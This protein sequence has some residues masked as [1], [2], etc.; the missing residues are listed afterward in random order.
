MKTTKQTGRL[1]GLLFLATFIA[2]VIG[3]INRGLSEGEVGTTEFIAN[4]AANDS[5]MKL[6]IGLDMLTGM[7][8]IVISI[9]LYPLME[10]LNKRIAIAYVL[11]AAINFVIAT[12]SNT[13]HLSLLYLVDSGRSGD[14]LQPF[15]TMFYN[16]YYSLH[17]LILILYSFNGATL[18]YFLIKS[19]LTHRWIAIWGLVASSLVFSG[20]FL[21]LIEVSVPFVLFAQNGI[22]MLT[23]ICY[24][25]VVG[26]RKELNSEMEPS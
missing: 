26:F 19:G 4:L 15:S 18:Y 21:Q 13:F 22:Y 23:F 12:L 17:F 14:I 20:G 5:Q 1:T 11:I 10:R 3:T 2:G 24:L 9:F 16:S 8:M 6:A 7:I 25:L